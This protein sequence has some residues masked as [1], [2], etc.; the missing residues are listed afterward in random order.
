MRRLTIAL[1]VSVA[2]ATALIGLAEPVAASTHKQ[3]T[4][5]ANGC[6]FTGHQ[7]SDPGTSWIGDTRTSDSDCVRVRTGIRFYGAGYG[8]R[9]MGNDGATSAWVGSG[10]SEFGHYTRHSSRVD[11]VPWSPWKYQ[12]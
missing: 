12:Y 11:G 2:V 10:T 4:W 5:T 6:T 7:W 8:Y 1:A 9:Y 3:Q